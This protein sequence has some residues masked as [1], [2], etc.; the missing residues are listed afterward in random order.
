MTH[1]D[2]QALSVSETVQ[3]IKTASPKVTN[4]TLGWDV[5]V[6]YDEKAINEILASA[7]SGKG[8]LKPITRISCCA[9]A[10]DHG[11][12]ANIDYTLE[13]G[14]PTIQFSTR[15]D[16]PTC[17]LAIP[18]VGGSATQSGTTESFPSGVYNVQI[19][20]IKLNASQGG[21][22]TPGTGSMSDTI[23]SGSLQPFI[24]PAGKST[25]GV[26][27]INGDASQKDM[28][29]IVARADGKEDSEST[30]NDYIIKEH[31][32]GLATALK[33]QYKT[34]RYEIARVKSDDPP[35]GFI[36]LFPKCFMFTVYTPRPNTTTA[37]V[38]SLFIQ[39]SDGTI[40]I[41][42]QDNL[43]LDWV[44]L[45]REKVK[46]S[47]IPTGQK[48]SIIFHNGMIVKTMIEPTLKSQGFSLNDKDSNKAPGKIELF[49]DVKK[50]IDRAEDIQDTRN[51]FGAPIEFKK[52]I[53]LSALENG[54][55][56]STS[57]GR[58][59]TQGAGHSIHSHGSVTV[60]GKFEK[61]VSGFT[62]DADNYILKVDFPIKKEDW[63]LIMD[64]DDV[65]WY[66]I[67][68]FGTKDIP[69]WV[70]DM[71]IDLPTLK[72]NLGK[73]KFFLTTNLLMPNQKIIK[74]DTGVGLQ[75]VGD[76]FLVGDLVNH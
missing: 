65:K 26:V 14:P 4:F 68:T 73:L 16:V 52:I 44:S 56:I 62:L 67:F 57:T 46:C 50:T 59:H 63:V 3:A 10:R 23:T 72:L 41:G 71:L 40:G 19:L 51:S 35:A 9:K 37:S 1:K 11:K 60:T 25:D 21:Y 49:I 20:N 70:H 48:A 54:A 55:S 17:D 39:T 75:V 36:K 15:I 69:S 29:I 31:Q 24:F 13:L 38:L 22:P 32:D 61:H 6:N 18:I 33:E 2:G 45:W 34:F 42:T 58:T 43:S 64:P 5:V 53:K 12:K 8:N 66:D 7:H 30:E 27:V 47:P 76:F 28:R 74:L